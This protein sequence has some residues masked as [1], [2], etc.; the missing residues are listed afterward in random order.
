MFRTAIKRGLR[1]LGYVVSRHD[2][3]HDPLA[4]RS[5]FLEMHGIN[6]VFDVGANVGQF[7]RQIRE[8]GYQ[9]RIV[10]F[11]PQSSAFAELES[12]AMQD[13]AWDVEHCALG[14]IISTAE[15]NVAGNSWSSSLLDM[16]PAHT[17]TAPTSTYVAKETVTV[18]TLDEVFPRYCGPNSRAFLKIDTQG[19]T[20]HVLQGAQHSI[21]A[22]QGIQVELSLIPLYSGEP[23]IGEVVAELYDKGFSLVLIEKEF[24][25]SRSG[26]QLQVNGIFFRL[27]QA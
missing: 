16:L 12:A 20:K 10:S 22:I 27:N 14:D 25:D 15:I 4:V 2:P 3:K 11:E 6:V 17:T 19:F 21:H 8:N 18:R 24:T 13:T 23:L 7:A 26:Q 9:G 1:K 5:H